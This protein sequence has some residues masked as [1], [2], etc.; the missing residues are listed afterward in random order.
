MKGIILAGGSG[1]RLHPMTMAVSKQMMPVYDKPM[2]YYPLSTL[3]L[4]GI[5]EIMI[6]S[7]PR[8]LPQF[9][10]LLR[11]GSQWGLSISY[12]EQPTPDGL[13]QAYVI[14]AEFVDRKPS[15]L[16]LGD[17]IF[18]GHGSTAL[19]EAAC[20]RPSG[21]SVF[22]YH[23]NDPERYGVI[24]FDEKRR[25]ISIEEKPASP[26]SNWAVTGLYFYDERVIDIAA[27]LTPSSRGELEI[28]DVNRAYLERGDLNVE[29]MGRGFAWLDTG[30]PESLIEAAEFVRT[31][32]KRQGVKIACPEEIALDQG[33]ID[34][35]QFEKLATELGKSAYGQ[36]LRKLLSIRH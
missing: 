2:I 6:I 8:D 12:A 28:T 32:E 25:A 31:I 5:R 26:K 30:T 17:N 23:V 3:M 24:E 11:D 4:A 34:L 18:Y 33:F 20:N 27:D 14:G 13:A 22:A 15:A 29:T 10:A 35:L 9:Q 1:T 19:F 16:I 21:A 7:T 36:Y